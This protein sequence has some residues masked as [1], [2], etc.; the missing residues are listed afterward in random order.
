MVREEAMFGTGFFPAEAS[1]YY[2]VDG[3]TLFLAGTAEVPLAGFHQ[4]EILEELPLRY[5][6]LSTCF[7]REAG[8]AGRDTAGIF[9]V[10]QFNKLEMFVYAAPDTSDRQHQAL[11]EIQEELVRGLGIPY[12]V[13]DIAAA[14]LGSPAARKFDI[15]AWLP[16]EGRYR[17]ITSCS[18]CTDFQARRLRVRRRS[19]NG[20]ELVHTLNGTAV[21]DR[22]LVFIAEHYQDADGAIVVPDALR[23]H[24]VAD[25]DRVGPV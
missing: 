10:H 17:E 13:V 16:S 3:R 6:G 9:R 8:A 1:E 4:G 19:T 7:R 24:L 22:W 2:E 14:D 15:E 18:N 12:R 21:V 25:V 11:L 23:P 20:T 5:A